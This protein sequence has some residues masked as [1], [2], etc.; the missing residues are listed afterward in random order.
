MLYNSYLHIS[1][2]I[3]DN[4]LT[5]LEEGL[6]IMKSVVFKFIFSL[7]T[8]KEIYN[9]ITDEEFEFLN[10]FINIFYRKWRNRRRLEKYS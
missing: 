1:K 5:F 4:D 3:K 6:N 7:A 2:Y 9:S 8:Y 10:N